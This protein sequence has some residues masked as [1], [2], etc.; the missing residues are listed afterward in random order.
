VDKP[1]QKPKPQTAA[2][3]PKRIYSTGEA[4]E[5]C[6]VSQQTIIRCF[7]AG[8]IGG[9][10]VPG[11]KFRRIPREELL[12]FM[13]ANA[14]P[15]DALDG[16]EPVGRV[17]IV[18]TT[19]SIADALAAALGDGVQAR[20][21]ADAFDAGRLLERGLPHLLVLVGA[22]PGLDEFPARA[23]L[24]ADGV[25]VLSLDTGLDPSEAASA[26]RAALDTRLR[27]G[28]DDTESARRG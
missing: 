19:P 16:L 26:I 4:A 9:F 13:R 6:K 3:V 27:A 5:L 8:R 20:I 17:L 7:D 10:R 12:R 14:I 22:V 2:S 24:A 21:A 18:C 15:T 23:R 1:D 11:S 25:D 28:A